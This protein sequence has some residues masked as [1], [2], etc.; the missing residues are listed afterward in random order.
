VMEWASVVAVE[1]LGA[2]WLLWRAQGPRATSLLLALLFGL[3]MVCCAPF[4]MHSPPYFG[5]HIGFLALAAGW[6]A[7]AAVV[8]W[9]A[10]SASNAWIRAHPER[11]REPPPARLVTRDRGHHE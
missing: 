8:G 6:L 9:V 10:R 3:G 2:A 11:D 7:L 5:M 1:A 4:V